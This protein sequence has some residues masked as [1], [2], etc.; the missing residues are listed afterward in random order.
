VEGKTGKWTEGIVPQDAWAAFGSDC[1]TE[2][3]LT[4]GRGCNAC[5][6]GHAREGIHIDIHKGLHG[7]R[8]QTGHWTGG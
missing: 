6:L 7:G 2:L 3:R 1:K 4:L 8:G 5:S